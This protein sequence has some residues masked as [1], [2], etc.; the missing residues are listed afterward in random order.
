MLLADDDPN[1]MVTVKK[2]GMI[3]LM[4]VFKDIIPGYRIRIATE[5]EKQQVQ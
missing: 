1:T 5:Q 3:T 4:E 2:L